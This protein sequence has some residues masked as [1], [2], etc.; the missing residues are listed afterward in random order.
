MINAFVTLVQATNGKTLQQIQRTLRFGKSDLVRSFEVYKDSLR[1]NAKN[2]TLLTANKVYVHESYRINEQ[3]RNIVTH[4]LDSGVEAVNFL[5]ATES[6]GIISDFVV[7]Q[8][9]NK[10]KSF[11]S[12]TSAVFNDSNPRIL[13]INAMYMRIAW[14]NVYE[15]IYTRVGDFYNDYS[16]PVPVDLMH[17]YYRHKFNYTKLLDLSASA[18]EIRLIDSDYTLLLILPDSSIR[19]LQSK[20]I[21]YDLTKIFDR[22]HG[23][24]MEVVIPK[25]KI[26]Y[27]ASLK[28]IMKTVRDS[29][30]SIQLILAKAMKSVFSIYR[31]QSQT[32]LIQPMLT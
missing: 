27:Q 24:F 21:N 16:R 18:I 22:M 19:D 25:F 17:F 32:Y 11:L 12:H 30:F 9:Q 14:T 28:D 10:I 29:Q 1:K 26:E 5:D 8:T 13:L 31:W 23:E 20:I 6:A 3:F 15:S 4:K 7:E 2:L